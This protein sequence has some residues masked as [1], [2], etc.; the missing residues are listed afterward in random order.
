MECA[1][2]GVSLSPYLIGSFLT[3]LWLNALNFFLEYVEL[4]PALFYEQVK[5]DS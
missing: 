3:K 4:P 5:A 2:R 1:R